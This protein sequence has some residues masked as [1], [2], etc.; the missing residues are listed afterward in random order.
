MST[1]RVAPQQ[2]CRLPYGARLN[3]RHRCGVLRGHRAAPCSEKLKG[4]TAAD[5]PFTGIENKFTRDGETTR[6]LTISALPDVIGNGRSP[7]LIPSHKATG[8]PSC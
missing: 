4:G 3:P 6:C 7:C 1:V 8:L 5:R 2:P